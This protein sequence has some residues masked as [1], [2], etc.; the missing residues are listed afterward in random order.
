[1]SAVLRIHGVAYLPC[2]TFMPRRVTGG[3]SALVL[4]LLICL[5]S[6]W[7]A[8]GQVTF[9]TPSAP[10]N[11]RSA[12]V[13]DLLDR[14]SAL[15]GERR[16]G[17]AFALY[18]DALRR[19]PSE[20]NLERRLTV[21]RVH[22]DLVRRYTDESFRDSVERMPVA[23]ALDLYAEVLLKI[24]SYYV[25]S[26]NWQQVVERGAESFAIAL[27]DGLYV[28]SHLASL[29]AARVERYRRDLPRAVAAERVTNRQQARLA[30]DRLAAAAQRQLGIGRTAVVMEFICGAANSLDPYSAYLTPSQLDEVYSQIEGNFVGLGIELKAHGGSLEILKVIDGS[31]ADRGG[32]QAGERIVEVDGR[33][34]GEYSTD[35]AANLLQGPEGSQ[36]EVVTRADSGTTR[37]LRLRREHVEVPSVDHV[38]LIDPTAGV[39]YVRLTCFQK[40][41]SRDLD[42][43]LWKLHRE[44][45]RS[46][47]LDL[48]GNPGGLLTTAVDVVDKFVDAGVIVS[49][50]GRSAQE[51]Y[52]YSAH[53]AGTWKLPLVVM[54]DGDSASASEIFAGAIRDHRRGTLV[55]TRT[56]GKG[57]VQGIFPLNLAGSGL[58]LT[59]ARFY[60]PKGHP[61]TQN[62]VEPDMLVHQAARANLESAGDQ[63]DLEPASDHEP[64]DPADDE[65]IQAALNAAKRQLARR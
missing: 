27:S 50:R 4:N 14:G 35:Q 6:V 49:T 15:E 44:G 36:V 65:A 64:L 61:F 24:Q 45:M 52:T 51:D 10:V 62:G 37:R 5:S 12:D 17:E 63:A 16:W 11:V 18:E 60:S 33:A 26:P 8:S 20:P 25:E 56:Y 32:M 13:S 53:T 39:G 55:G 1:M 59:T 31:P 47:I 41:T 28:E 57:S 46:L 40:T 58:R 22:Y 9:V 21:A 48:R 7:T 38:Q 19:F 42:A 29:P 23:Q 34:T 2:E 43:A 30:V 3:L 54:I